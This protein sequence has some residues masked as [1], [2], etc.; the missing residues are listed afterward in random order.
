MTGEEYLAKGAVNVYSF[1]PIL[2]KDGQFS[3]W[4]LARKDS[5]QPRCAVG[6]IEPGH[7]ICILC[8][9]RLTRSDGVTLNQLMQ[10]MKARGCTLAFNLDG[11][12]TAAMTFM[13]QRINEI[14]KYESNGK[15]T[16]SPRKTTEVMGIGISEQVGQIEFQ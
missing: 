11:G 10:M 1:G 7:Y 4:V 3:D 8:E 2:L 14:G 5:K 15:M 6:M 12:Q 13:G 16:T 9:G